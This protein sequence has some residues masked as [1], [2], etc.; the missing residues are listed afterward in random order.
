M[1]RQWPSLA[2]L[3]LALGT[4][5]AL[6]ILVMAGQAPL[7]ISLLAMLLAVFLLVGAS[8]VA[9]RRLRRG[10]W[11]VRVL[12]IVVSVLGCLAFLIPQMARSVLFYPNQDETA[13]AA[14]AADPRMERVSL[15]GGYAGWFFHQVSG[16]APLVIY[17]GGN[18]ECAAR[19]V[20]GYGARDG[21]GVLD[22]ANLLAVD[23]P[24]YGDSS[25]SPSQEAIF[26]MALAVFDYARSRPDVDPERIV[27]EGYSLGTGPATY[28]A[29]QREEA[30]LVL[31]APYDNAVDLYNQQLDIFHGP[32]R[33]LVTQHFDSDRYAPGVEVAPLIITSV[34]DEQ[35]SHRLSEALARSFTPPAPVQMFDGLGHNDYFPDPGVRE[36]IHD[37]LQEVTA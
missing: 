6:A 13:V 27:V 24:G 29:S 35:I 7:A 16:P 31:V 22:G 18:G 36:A 23:Y 33:L 19:T 28:A 17:F 1:R 20:S 5:C 15:D 8:S 21:W 25:G 10:R 14:L 34:D 11:A 3:A 2:A 32:L 9:Q 12:V 26:T 37:Y 30:G 4:L